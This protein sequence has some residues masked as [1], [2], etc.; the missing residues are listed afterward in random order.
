MVTSIHRWVIFNLVGVFGFVV[1]LTV[2]TLLIDCFHWG[3]V[4]ATALAV[5]TAVIHNFIWH[6]RWTWRD[7]GNPGYC[8]AFRRFLRFNLSNGTLSIVGNIIFMTIF[9]DTLPVNF[10]VANILSIGVC[11]IINYVLS[12]R[13]VFKEA[14]R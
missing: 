5:E 4:P 3:Y 9:M 13:L 10:A 8:G 12:D 11:S 7:R 1:Q 14:N 2:L 6:E